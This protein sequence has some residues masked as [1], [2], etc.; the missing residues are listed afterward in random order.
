MKRKTVIK[1]LLSGFA[2]LTLSGLLKDEI[3]TVSA[4]THSVTL[5]RALAA[6]NAMQKYFY[7]QDGSSLYL[8]QYPPAANDR[9]YS[10]EWPF[11][12]A[13]VATIDLLNIPGETG[14]NFREAVQDRSRGQEHYW[15][16]TGATNV[17][18]YDSYPR[19]P[20]GDGGDKFYDDNEWVG[21]AKIQLYLMTK[22][23]A[24]LKRAKE[25]FTLVVSGWDT[26]PSHPAPG[27]VFWTQASWSQD[28]NTVSN[29]PGAEMGLRLYQITGERFYFDW[30][31]KMY[32]WTNEHLLAPNGLYW[33]NV[34]MDGTI[35]KTQWSY[36]Q[37]VPIGVNVLFYQITGDSVYLQR[38]KDI[39]NAALDF[40]GSENRLYKQPACFNAI[41]FKNLLLLY[42]KTH[43]QRYLR[44]MQAYA[45]TVWNQYRDPNT[46]L[47]HI[48]NQQATSLLEQAAM[49]QIYAVLAWDPA[50]YHLLY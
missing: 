39:A 2:S 17:A 18:G 5:D 30:A 49:T 4:S 9:P 28:R 10:Y 8:E 16:P 37:G 48:E 21:L 35:D 14:R 50:Q 23:Q 33:D 11:S 25:I 22:D 27:G 46:N 44:A 34:H 6:Y 1:L 24:A 41:F 38:A 20:Y 12:Q 29:M 36:N 42:T 43:E 47:F 15:N 3:K 19:S 32:D 31:K 7:K 26:D 13:H 40:Y 45:D